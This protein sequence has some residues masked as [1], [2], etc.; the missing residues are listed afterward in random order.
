MT[1][2]DPHLV[3]IDEIREAAARNKIASLSA[4]ERRRGVVT[5]S[6]GNHAQAVARAA[7]LLG[8]KAVICMPRDAPRISIQGVERDARRSSSPGRTRRS[9]TPSLCACR[10]PI[11]R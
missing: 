7:R 6:S 3:S 11:R 1:V 4:E 5:Y 2:A 9:A 8:V 10:H